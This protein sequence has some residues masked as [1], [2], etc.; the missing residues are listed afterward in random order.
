MQIF[1]PSASTDSAWMM[2]L[3]FGW[4]TAAKGVQYPEWWGLGWILILELQGRDLTQ[5]SDIGKH[6]G[7]VKL[8]VTIVHFRVLK[9]MQIYLLQWQLICETWKPISSHVLVNI[10][11]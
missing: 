3:C 9:N 7:Q 2:W 6:D 1:S 10:L 11:E 8:I 4:G 5:K